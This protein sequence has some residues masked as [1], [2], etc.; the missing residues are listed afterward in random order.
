V[1]ERRESEKRK[2]GEIAARKTR[3]EQMII[4]KENETEKEKKMGRKMRRGTKERKKGEVY[5]YVCAFV[6]RI[7]G[8]PSYDL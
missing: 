4:S 7:M 1:E 6:F 3:G 5:V 2:R 8:I